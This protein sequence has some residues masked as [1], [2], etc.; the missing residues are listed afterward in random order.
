MKRVL[1]YIVISFLTISCNE[2][3]S[4]IKT[5]INT[6]KA[7]YLLKIDTNEVISNIF[8]EINYES[9]RK[10]HFFSIKNIDSL[11]NLVLKQLS[12]ITSD[13]FEILKNGKKLELDKLKS[14]ETKNISCRKISYIGVS[15]EFTLISYLQACSDYTN[16]ILIIKHSSNEIQSL[17][18]GNLYP[19]VISTE[20]LTYKKIELTSPKIIFDYLDYSLNKGELHVASKIII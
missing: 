4:S 5:I 1:I 12:L 6:E 10:S 7:K 13:S 17:W 8:L 3:T 19:S 14:Q 11:P 20:E 15:E 9:I 18:I 16:N 2:E